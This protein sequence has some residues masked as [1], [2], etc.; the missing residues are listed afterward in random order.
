MGFVWVSFFFR[1]FRVNFMS[2]EAH[3]TYCSN[4][5]F[6]KMASLHDMAYSLNFR[7]DMLNNNAAP[8]IVRGKH[9]LE[10]ILFRSA[11]RIPKSTTKKEKQLVT[12]A[13][14]ASIIS[15]SLN[16]PTGGRYSTT[17]ATTFQMYASHLPLTSYQCNNLTSSPPDRIRSHRTVQAKRSV[18]CLPYH[19]TADDCEHQRD[20]HEPHVAGQIRRRKSEDH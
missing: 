10:H 11:E 16:C 17:S 2:F 18:Y 20:S 8:F 3:F 14:T 13:L 7:E 15:G 9:L 5:S 1:S 6:Q 4:K 19:T 12:S